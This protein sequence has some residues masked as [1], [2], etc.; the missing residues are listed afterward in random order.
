[1]F[2]GLTAPHLQDIAR[3]APDALLLTKFH[4]PA[5][6]PNQVSRPALLTRLDQ[7]V[8]LGHRLTLLSAPAGFG[9][10]TLIGDWIASLARPAAWI[11]LDSGD[12]D[13]LVFVRCLAAALQGA[14]PDLSIEPPEEP[15][16]GITT[17]IN[18]LVRNPNEQ[19]LV[20][21][22]YHLVT[23]FAVHDLVGFLL[24]RQPAGFHLVVGTREDPPL[25]LA[26]LRARGQITE[27][28][29]RDL[30]FNRLEASTFL[31]QTMGLTLSEN[32]VAS[33]ESRTEGWVTGLQLA[34]LALRRQ[35]GTEAFIADFAGDDRFI[36]DYLMAEVLAGEDQ[37]VRTFLQQTS[38]LTQFCAPLCDALTGREDSRLVLNHLESANLFVIPLDNKRDWYRY[39]GLFAE[40]LRLK[41]PAGEQIELHHRAA[42]WYSSHEKSELAEK[43]IRRVAELAPAV[44]AIRQPLTEQPLIEP[45]SERETQVLELIAAGYS[46]A[47][48]ARKLFIAHG[49]VK[50]HINNIYGRLGA[51]SRTQA[52]AISRRLGLLD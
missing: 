4:I 12:N 49:T 22:D 1:M 2:G 48:I 33:L 37:G 51:S 15:A 43:H 5:S 26:R 19:I 28:R 3:M 10:T 27:I 7:G 14:D 41:L 9:K 16:D 50:R 42:Q 40:A 52:V 18:A 39:H 45:L 20:L 44:D 23:D 25:P 34:G 17:I 38:L 31:T 11:N 21:D 35:S 24:E 32:S 30:R 47:D 6:R 13:P 36:V 46:N 8:T 29:E